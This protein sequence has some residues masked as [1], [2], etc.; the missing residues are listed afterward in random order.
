MIRVR[1]LIDLTVK[2]ENGKVKR[3]NRGE[4]GYFTVEDNTGLFHAPVRGVMNVLID[5]KHVAEVN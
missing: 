5:R 3:V 1:L 4:L 2:L